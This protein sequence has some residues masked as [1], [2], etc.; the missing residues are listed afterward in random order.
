MIR[1]FATQEHSA[2]LAQLASRMSA[3]MKFGAG[4]G[5]DIFAKVKGLITCLINM[6]QAEAPSEDVQKTVHVPQSMFENIATGSVSE[7]QNPCQLGAQFRDTTGEHRSTHERITH[8]SELHEIQQRTNKVQCQRCPSYIEDGFQVCPCGGQL[9]MSEEMLSSIKQKIKHLTAD[10]YMTSHGKNIISLP[11]SLCERSTKR[12][13]TRRFLTACR[14]MKYFMQ[15]SS[16][17]HG[18]KS[19]ANNW[20]T[21]EQLLFRTKPLQNNWN[22]TPRCIIFGTIR[23]KWKEDP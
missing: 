1:R 20:I 13:S 16:N 3:V 8:G 5:D 11:K 17:I 15:A 10:A 7:S 2:V 19:G 21:S 14:T 6:L 4:T 9:N 23:N 12:E 22:D 18:R